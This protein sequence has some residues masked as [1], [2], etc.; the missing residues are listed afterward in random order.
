MSKAKSRLQSG[1][2]LK[3]AI[4]DLTDCEGCELEF[5]NLREKLPDFLNQVEI[6]NWRLIVDAEKWKN[7]DIAFV[8]GTPI[9]PEEIELLKKIR[10]NAKYVTALGTCACTGGIPALIDPA[11]R[12]K[13][14][15]QIYPK[16]DPKNSQPAKPIA[17]Y[18]KIDFAIGGCPVNPPDIERFLAS[19]LAGKTPLQ[20]TYPVCLACKAKQ[21]K[22]LLLEDKSCMGPVTASGCNAICPTFG[23]PCFGCLGP[24]EDANMKALYNRF[25][26]IKI[27]EKEMLDWASVTWRNLEEYEKFEKIIKENK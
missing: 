4:F 21:N 11:K 14:F 25:K 23:F 16:R 19:V 1:K 26:E 27:P 15:K 22:C 10:E 17:H 9:K 20:K 18:I 13:V 12:E 24:M 6:L 2:K 8:E 7:I 5:L 3:I